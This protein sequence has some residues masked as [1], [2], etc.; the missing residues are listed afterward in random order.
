MQSEAGTL[1]MKPFNAL[2]CAVFA[3]F[4]LILI[5][6]SKLVRNKSEKT[7]RYILAAASFLT[8]IFFF[9]YKYYLSLD[10][11]YRIV[12]AS[13]GGFNWWSELPLHLCNINMILITVAMLWNNRALMRFCF[14]VG[15]LGATM[16]LVMPGIGFSGYSILLPRMLGF[17]GTHFAIVIEAL[18]IVT[19]GLY[20]PVIRDLLPTAL[21][22][23]VIGFG[24]HCINTLMRFTG[25][26][27]KANYFFSY[28]TEGNPLLEIFHKWIPYPFLYLLPCIA[29]LAVYMSLIMLGFHISDKVRNS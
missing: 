12:N 22:I 6:A 20:K 17:Y 8:L 2:F 28:E 18:A 1:I 13:M 26:N 21:S 15:P 4:I 29:I 10:A 23:L 3:F 9:I 24:V 16:A 25:I 5:I 27:P 11:E 14:F 19:F 7:K